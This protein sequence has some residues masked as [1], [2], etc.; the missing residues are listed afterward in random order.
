MTL[1]QVFSC[2]VYQIFKNTFFCR[3]PP[4]SASAFPVGAFVF[5]FQKGNLTAISYPCYDVLI[6]FLL[7]TWFDA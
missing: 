5:F 4:V 1:T 6:I 2:E 3:T 7:D